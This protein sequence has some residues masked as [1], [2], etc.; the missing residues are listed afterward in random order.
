[1]DVSL[2]SEFLDKVRIT[3]GERIADICTHKLIN[4][5]IENIDEME[6]LEEAKQEAGFDPERSSLAYSKYLFVT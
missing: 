3:Y 6:I 1:M 5:N 2:L 4:Q